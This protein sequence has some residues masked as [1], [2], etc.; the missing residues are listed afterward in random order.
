MPSTT[1]GTDVEGRTTRDK[2]LSS[3][4]GHDVSMKVPRERPYKMIAAT[5][6]SRRKRIPGIPPTRQMKE[7][8]ILALIFHGFKKVDIT[9]SDL[10]ASAKHAEDN[11]DDEN[12]VAE[13]NRKRIMKHVENNL[14]AYK[15]RF[16]LL[17]ACHQVRH[18]DEDNVSNFYQM[19]DDD[20]PSMKIIPHLTYWA[21]S[22]DVFV[23]SSSTRERFEGSRYFEYH[24][25]E[26]QTA[27]I[28]SGAID[29]DPTGGFFTQEEKD[30]I[31][32]A[33]DDKSSIEAAMRIPGSAII[34]AHCVLE[35]IGRPLQ[36]WYMRKR[37][38]ES[39]PEITITSAVK[40]LRHALKMRT[41][42]DVIQ[43]EDATMDD[44]R[45][46]AANL[47]N[48]GA[49]GSLRN[50]ANQAAAS[51]ASGGHFSDDASGVGTVDFHQ[52]FT[53]L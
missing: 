16:I 21:D 30:A 4:Q 42:T 39:T 37:H 17:V 48:T 29:Q 13:H 2:L 27:A 35:A 40:L 43:D 9:D 24:T 53:R 31:H 52:Q 41:D 6:Y 44:V 36:T 46:A 23:E 50:G 10:E 8:F 38:L 47:F 20:C 12:V 32:A 3:L 18:L 5:A 7:I 28:C 15:K 22:L 1:T 45:N 34:K 33:K 25:A 51:I 19:V 11:P 49:V 26:S 14:L